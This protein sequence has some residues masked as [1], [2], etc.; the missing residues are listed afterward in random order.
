MDYPHTLGEQKP[1]PAGFEL[2]APSTDVELLSVRTVQHEAYGELETPG[3]SEVQSL[4][5][6]LQAGG[7][8]VLAQTGIG[9]V[10]AGAGEYSPPF[11]GVT[12]IT[13]VG[14]RPEY[15]RRGLAAAMTDWLIRNTVEHDIPNAFLMANA[16][17][18]GIYASV[19]FAMRGQ[20][21][22]IRAHA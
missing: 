15:R 5:R 8:A 16:T 20:I 18:Q 14:V 21:L 2:L 12:E 11:A 4:R 1:V 9:A 10:A 22:H 19:G 7:G 3:A 6:A 13:S 17:G